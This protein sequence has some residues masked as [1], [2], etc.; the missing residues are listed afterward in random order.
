M[1]SVYIYNMM[2]HGT[3]V[4][5]NALAV[6]LLAGKFIMVLAIN[7]FTNVKKWKKMFSVVVG[8]C[9]ACCCIGF[10]LRAEEN[11]LHLQLG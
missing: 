7:K 11:A 5:I 1:L 6:V 9:G 10:L 3:P 8:S 2:K 4:I